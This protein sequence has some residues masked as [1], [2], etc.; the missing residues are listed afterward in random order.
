MRIGNTFLMILVAIL[1]ISMIGWN[2]LAGYYRYKN[3]QY[4]EKI[5]KEMD[6]EEKTFKK[7]WECKELENGELKCTMIKG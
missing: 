6:E 4:I 7:I 3:E 1:L 2:I 5:R